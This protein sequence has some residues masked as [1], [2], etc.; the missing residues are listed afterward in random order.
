[1]LE[2]SPDEIIV[3]IGFNI[4]PLA[5]V[6]VSKVH[7]VFKGAEEIRTQAIVHC[8]LQLTIAFGGFFLLLQVAIS[9][10]VINKA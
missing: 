3:V 4:V 10:H 2:H 7:A 9:Y 8:T 6:F 1:M 5:E